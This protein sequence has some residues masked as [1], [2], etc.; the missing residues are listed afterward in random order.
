MKPHC[1]LFVFLSVVLITACTLKNTTKGVLHNT[2]SLLVQYPDSALRLLEMQAEIMSEESEATQMYYFLLLTKANEA[3][4]IP[5]TSDSLIKRVVRYY[6]EHGSNQQAAE[7][8]YYQGCV[9]RDLNDVDYALEAFQLATY[10][11]TNPEPHLAGLAYNQMGN[12]F[13]YQKLDYEAMEAYREAA[14]YAKKENDSIALAQRLKH[15]A[16]AFIALNKADSALHYYGLALQ[17]NPYIYQKDIEKEKAIL[18]IQLKDFPKARKA[19]EYNLDAYLTWADYYHGVNKKDSASHYYAYALSRK[20]TNELQRKNI[21]QRLSAY[22]EEQGEIQKAYFYLKL[23]N[24]IQDTLHNRYESEA[25]R[26]AQL[27]HTYRNAAH[28]K[29]QKAGVTTQAEPKRKDLTGMIIGVVVSSGIAIVLFHYKRKKRPSTSLTKMET[30]TLYKSAIYQ[31]IKKQAHNP[32]FKL[33]D[34]QW[35]ELQIE[36]DQ[37]YNHFTARLYAICPKLNE[38]ELHVCYLLKLSIAPTDIAHIIV[39]QVSTVSSIRERLYKKIHGTSGNAKQ[40][41]DFILKF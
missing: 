7:A 12:L 27:I 22:A 4:G 9:Y 15:T 34:E 13:T 5:H 35:Q 24:R 6:E 28:K 17:T 31:L 37:A 30:D 41:D 10:L 18:Y 11:P 3:C 25:I 16:L 8:Y 23:A 2:D 36:M 39:R 19:L 38:T 20:E 29:Y 1:Y 40:L 14:N 26:Q 21:Y 32:D 33:T